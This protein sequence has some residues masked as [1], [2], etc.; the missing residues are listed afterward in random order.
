MILVLD[1]RDS[2]AELVRK[3]IDLKDAI[4][5]IRDFW[6]RVLEG[7]ERRRQIRQCHLHQTEC[8]EA[9]ATLL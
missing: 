3:R 1:L 8:N 5:D 4:D 2:V 9:V 7:G 6:L